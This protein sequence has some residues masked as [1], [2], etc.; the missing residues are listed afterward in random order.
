MTPLRFPLWP[1]LLALA[2]LQAGTAAAQDTTRNPPPTAADRS[3]LARLPDWSGVW[4]PNISDQNAQ[5]KGNPVPWKPLVQTVIDRLEA[6]DKVGRPKG[7][8]VD[9]LPH[10]M[11]GWMIKSHNALALLFTPS[12]VTV[13]GEVDGNR[14]RRSY[15]DGRS[16]PD[17]P[18][19][20]F[21]GHSI[22]HWEGPHG[23]TPVVDT[24]G[25]L[26]LQT[27]LAVSEA[28]GVPNSGDLQVVERIRLASP[29]NLTRGGWTRHAF[30]PG[31]KVE[32][33]PS[34]LRDGDAGG[35]FRK[36]TLL[37][38]GTVWRSNLRASETPRLA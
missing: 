20:S 32:V 2:S 35:A 5:I 8:R 31:D 14:L 33:E 27:H 13:L 17:D 38:G 36:G 16:H 37:D 11:P 34:P 3:A 24:V 21:H 25:A 4:I 6:E 29:G 18:A 23:D 9:C 28:V 7:L 26:P 15:T 30:K 10:G 1:A 22:G 12:R 19:P